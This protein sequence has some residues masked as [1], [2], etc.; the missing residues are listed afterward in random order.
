[1]NSEGIYS[2]ILPCDWS[3]LPQPYLDVKQQEIGIVDHDY[4][5]RSS[6]LYG[7]TATITCG[8]IMQKNIICFVDYLL[9]IDKFFFVSLL[10]FGYYFINIS[11]LMTLS[12]GFIYLMT[13]SYEPWSF[14]MNFEGI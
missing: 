6:F 1:M 5:T 9:Y 7:T 12:R 3:G 11:Y 10:V 4:G 8:K 13:L 2:F 14:W